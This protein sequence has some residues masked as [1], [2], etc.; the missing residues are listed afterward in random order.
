MIKFKKTAAIILAAVL[1][2]STFAGCDQKGKEPGADATATPKAE[3]SSSKDEAATTDF[4]A[5]IAGQDI[6]ASTFYYFLY[7]GLREIYYK[8]NVYD[9]D[10]SEEENVEK[11]IEF[12]ESVDEEG[13]TYLDR[14]IEKTLD[15]AAGFYAS[16]MVG[17]Q[18]GE[19]NADNAITQKEIDEMMAAIDEE[20]DYASSYYSCSRDDYCKAYY[21][22]NV[23]DMK[24]YSLVQLY[25]AKHKE[26]WQTAQG[27]VFDAE[28]PKKPEAPKELSEN[29]SQEEKTK[30]DK[31]YAE[32][33]TKLEKY[34]TEL[35]AYEKVLAEYWEKFRGTY[36]AGVN[37][38]GINDFDIVT[39]RYL[40]VSTLDEDGKALSEE[41]KAEKKA[42]AEKYMEYIKNGLDFEKFV[43]G[44]SDS[45]TVATDGGLVDIDKESQ[46]AWAIPEEAVEWARDDS[47][48]VSDELA[49]FSDGKG[50]YIVQKVGFTDFDKTEGIVASTDT[51]SPAVVKSNVEYK[52]L[53]D[54]Y[55][56]VV[57]ELLEKDEY[58]VTE[59][60]TELMKQLAE[61]FLSTVEDSASK[62]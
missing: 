28:E 23:N 20:M 46:S 60:N 27:Y 44:F 18:A 14:V 47:N 24:R 48:K 37:D 40:Y 5:R 34:E 49:L 7:S 61:K 52:V 45:E 59:K 41:K 3:D 43:K 26:M 55:N 9:D 30:Y 33:K 56:A 31:E 29:A 53:V 38:N 12:M 58:K 2:L 54:E 21:A 35:A 4:V 39:V 19:E 1:C 51:A 36:D 25:A 42:E 13:V 6:Y 62:E 8:N 15:I 57:Q 10:L 50:F 32:Y 16:S 11:M 17:K 22:M